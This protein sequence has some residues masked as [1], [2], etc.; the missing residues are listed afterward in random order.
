[1]EYLCHLN[2]FGSSTSRVRKGG[3]GWVGE[4]AGRVSVGSCCQQRGLVLHVPPGWNESLSSKGN[5]Q[6]MSPDESQ[7]GVMIKYPG[8]SSKYGVKC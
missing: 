6:V 3:G 2:W 1:M 5:A 4:S 8:Q 7:T